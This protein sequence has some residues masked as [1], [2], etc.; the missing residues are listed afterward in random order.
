[1]QQLT[2]PA[3][4]KSIQQLD[5][6][7][8][9]LYEQRLYP[10]SYS[11]VGFLGVN[12]KL[13]DTVSKDLEYLESVNITTEQ[14]ANR[15]N[16]IIKQYFNSDSDHIIDG[17]F[18]ITDSICTK[19]HQE[20]P[21]HELDN[22]KKKPSGSS[23]Y[24]ITNVETGEK[25]WFPI[26]IIHL[27][28]AHGFFEGKGSSYRVEPE[29]VIR[30]LEIEPDVDYSIRYKNVVKWSLRMSSTSCDPSNIE[31]ME[32]SKP[33]SLDIFSAQDPSSSEKYLLLVYP[34]S[35]TNRYAA[36]TSGSILERWEQHVRSETQKKAKCKYHIQFRVLSGLPA[37][38][39]VEEKVQ[40]KIN[41]VKSRIESYNN[42]VIDKNMRVSIYLLPYNYNTNTYQS[43]IFEQSDNNAVHIKI[44]KLDATFACPRKGFAHYSTIMSKQFIFE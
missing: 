44:E 27:I 1:M 21:F 8:L 25:F 13:L 19:G 37:E 18:K 42:S 23:D 29:T 28:R 6:D 15:L 38:F 36:N 22:D 11:Q 14:I 20:C 32:N 31:E 43:A 40:N 17:K 34:E 3:P 41:K 26:L 7:E 12:D 16:R 24:E 33:F 39:D 30:I 35:Y 5:E 9:V 2:Y 10:N 4:K